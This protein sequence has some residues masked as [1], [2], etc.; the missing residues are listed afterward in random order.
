MMKFKEY[1]TRNG[2]IQTF[3]WEGLCSMRKLQQEEK[4]HAM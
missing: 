3:Y 4:K 2:Y 1:V